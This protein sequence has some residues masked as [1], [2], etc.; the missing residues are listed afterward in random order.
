[1][2]T[3][4]SRVKS[5]EVTAVSGIRDIAPDSFADVELVLAEEVARGVGELRFGGALGVDSIALAAACGAT[6]ERRVF[7]PFTL[8]DQPVEAREVVAASCHARGASRRA[9][10]R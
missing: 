10:R 6:A 7:V 2:E 4:M 8:R 5:K 3:R 9:G 1:M